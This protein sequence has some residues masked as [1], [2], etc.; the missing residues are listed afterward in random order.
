MYWSKSCF[1]LIIEF[2]EI[3]ELK[4]MEQILARPIFGFSVRKENLI[5]VKEIKFHN[6]P[7]YSA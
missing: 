6:S 4:G 5:V 2:S 1:I 7:S 3:I